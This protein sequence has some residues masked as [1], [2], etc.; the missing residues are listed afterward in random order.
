MRSRTKQT[1]RRLAWL[2]AL[3]S[4]LAI[5]AG[6]NRPVGHARSLT[7]GERDSAHRTMP[8]P[9]PKHGQHYVE[10]TETA[11]VAVPPDALLQWVVMTPLE[12]VLT[13]FGD[14]PPVT[15]TV[16]LT[17]TWGD[18]ESRRRVELEGGDSALEELVSYEPGRRFEYVVWNF[19][20]RARLA[21]DFA[22]ADFVVEPA[23]GGSRLI[24]TYRF[25]PRG[26]VSKGIL[27]RFVRDQYAG[28]MRECMANIER[29][30]VA[31][32]R[33]DA[34]TRVAGQSRNVWQDIP[35]QLDG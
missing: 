29:L 22:V 8:R 16:L 33:E 10:H 13:G 19:T 3:V 2:T 11:T 15:H 21:T 5:P 18:A 20:N 17:D 25:S 12:D 4:T 27:E 34:S 28:F 30:A 7:P 24:W 9:V 32:L 1:R 6:C 26:S 23:D 35:A 31:E 14:L